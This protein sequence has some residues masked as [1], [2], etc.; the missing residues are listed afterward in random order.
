VTVLRK[1]AIQKSNRVFGGLLLLGEEEVF[2]T[3]AA[4]P[5]FGQQRE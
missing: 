2:W 1:P 3:G 5:Q 4:R